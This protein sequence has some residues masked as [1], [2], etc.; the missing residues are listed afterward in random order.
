MNAGADYAGRAAGIDTNSFSTIFNKP[1]GYGSTLFSNSGCS[2]ETVPPVTG[3]FV[4]GSLGSCTA[5]TRVLIEG[6]FGIWFK[7]YDGAREK[8]N[9]GR[10]Q[11]GPQFSY[12]DRN[13]WVGCGSSGASCNEP[14]GLDAMI[15]TS[16]RYY[17]P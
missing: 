4:P 12:V 5:D 8:V 17:L 1:V 16:F 10:I 2:S 11:W 14:H 9:R 7:P 6:T 15:F 3:G 13:T